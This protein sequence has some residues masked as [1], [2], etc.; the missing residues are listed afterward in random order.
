MTASVALALAEKDGSGCALGE[1]V[2][3]SV[4]ASVVIAAAGVY[5]VGRARVPRGLRD[6]AAQTAPVRDRSAVCGSTATRGCNSHT[7]GS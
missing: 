1:A 3:A 7:P 6:R 2:T 5:D 4:W